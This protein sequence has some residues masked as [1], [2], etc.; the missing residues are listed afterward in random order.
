MDITY[1]G[2]SSFRIKTKSAVIITDPVSKSE[3]DIVLLSGTQNLTESLEL[4]KG[5]H[6][7]ITAPGEYEIMEVSFIGIKFSDTTAYLIEA[8]G[9]RILFAG[10]LNTK[11][12]DENISQFGDIDILLLPVGGKDVIDG[13]SAAEATRQV[14][15]Y[16]V[17]PYFFKQKGLEDQVDVEEFL[18]ETGMV[19][20]RNQKFSIKK[21]E[22]INHLP[23]KVI[24]LEPNK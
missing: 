19:V 13:K 24:L 14:E 7:E 8:D 15:P 12:N 17:V 10:K 21:D 1:L 20:E 11:L 18:K 5:F 16:F 3:G 22:I 6:K 23:A 4:V 2:Q 9:L